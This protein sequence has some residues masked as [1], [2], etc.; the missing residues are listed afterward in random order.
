MACACVRACVCV[1]AGDVSACVLRE[2]DSEKY[3]CACVCTCMSACV[4]VSLRVCECACVSECACVCECACV[5]LTRTE[6][7]SL[8]RRTVRRE[9][10]SAHP[11]AASVP[12]KQEHLC[13]EDARLSTVTR[14]LLL[15]HSTFSAHS[16]SVETLA[17]TQF[18]TQ[19]YL[20][21]TSCTHT[22]A[23]TQLRNFFAT[24]DASPNDVRRTKRLTHSV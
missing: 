23:Q 6:R 7:C 22:H 10:G 21:C 24:E 15:Q 18:D 1:C 17:T 11:R 13:F 16:F 2:P 20:L 5:V 14:L 19:L 8:P 3:V 9:T 4:C 12:T